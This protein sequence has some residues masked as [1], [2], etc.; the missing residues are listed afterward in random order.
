[1]GDGISRISTSGAVPQPDRVSPKRDREREEQLDF[2]EEMEHRE[3]G[4]HKEEVPRA[5]PDPP[6]PFGISRGGTR[7]VGYRVDD[8]A[9]GELDLSA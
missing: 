1:M 8:E 3:H 2:A 6:H 4:A 9:G 7:P 5:I